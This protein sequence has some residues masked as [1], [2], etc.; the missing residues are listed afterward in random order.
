M[1]GTAVMRPLA[2]VAEF[3]GGPHPER[4]VASPR[5]GKGMSYFVE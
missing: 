4:T 5:P 3:I 2:V 1:R